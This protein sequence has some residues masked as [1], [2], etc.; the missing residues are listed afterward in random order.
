MF[1]FPYIHIDSIAFS[2]QDVQDPRSIIQWKIIQQ[3]LSNFMEALWLYFIIFIDSRQ[4]G[5]GWFV[6]LHCRAIC[7][8][9]ASLDYLI[10]IDWEINILIVLIGLALQIDTMIS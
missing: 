10:D 6:V 7:L 3:L 4:I 9:L 2:V 1:W 8:S 5:M